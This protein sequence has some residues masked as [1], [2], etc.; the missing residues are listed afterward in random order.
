VVDVRSH[1]AYKA[2]AK[3]D[4]ANLVFK[5]NPVMEFVRDE[6]KIKGL[7]TGHVASRFEKMGFKKPEDFARFD[8]ELVSDSQMKFEWGFEKTEIRK[9]REC[10]EGLR[11]GGIV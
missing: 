2:V 1:G 3:P 9:I 11:A 8:E 7:R 5:T 10:C 4:R 6:M